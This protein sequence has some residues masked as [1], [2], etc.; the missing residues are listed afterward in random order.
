M[1]ITKN[2]RGLIIAFFLPFLFISCPTIWH[3]YDYGLQDMHR[4]RARFA[5]WEIQ[6]PGDEIE[7]LKFALMIGAV[8]GILAGAFGVGLY[9][10]ASLTKRNF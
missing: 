4:A 8:S 7:S 5:G 2:K 9:G 1:S 10:V 3:W 6:Q